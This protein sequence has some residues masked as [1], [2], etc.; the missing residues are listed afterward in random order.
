MK[1]PLCRL[2]PHPL[3]TAVH[4]F[5]SSG[6]GMSSKWAE[7]SWASECRALGPGSVVGVTVTVAQAS[8]GLPV[9]CV[10]WLEAAEREPLATGF[11]ALAPLTWSCGGSMEAGW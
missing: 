1:V 10:V 11:R 2:C 7:V 6:L 8:G 5:N 9:L 4:P 3:Y